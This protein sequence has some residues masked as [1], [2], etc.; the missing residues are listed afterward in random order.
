[1]M[2]WC[3]RKEHATVV[4]D[5]GS[6]SVGASLVVIDKK[7]A[8]RIVVS[9]RED[10]PFRKKLDHED[11]I[12]NT[13]KTIENVLSQVTRQASGELYPR[14]VHVFLASHLFLPSL[15]RLHI[16][17]DVPFYVTKNFVDELIKIDV[18]KYKTE[19]FEKSLEEKKNDNV[20]FESKIPR[21]CL[22]GY[23]TQNPYDK[24]A[25]DLDIT[26]YIGMA[27]RDF[28]SGISTVVGKFYAGIVP[29][30]HSF[31]FVGFNVVSDT[32]LHDNNFVFIDIG[33]ELTEVVVCR[34][35]SISGLFSF[36]VGKNSL[37]RA[38][39]ERFSVGKAQ[40]LSLVRMYT[41]KQANSASDQKILAAME[42]T[43]LKFTDNLKKALGVLSDKR[44][45]PQAFYLVADDDV[46]PVFVEYLKS[47]KFGEFLA[48][49]K[50]PF[51][52]VIPSKFMEKFC[53][54]QAGDVFMTIEAIF[55]DKLE[56][57]KSW[58]L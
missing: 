34:E 55:V 14:S 22:N 54:G 56:K 52:M 48:L 45:L 5:V 3:G 28:I 53:H 40:A 31:P 10:M 21:I 51:S 9:A 24:Y 4:V 57:I 7:D 38:I 46:S 26:A 50:E 13:F 32:L 1:M 17:K 16:Q 58:L 19:I 35:N 44:L 12:S 42:D 23:R 6:S 36:P 47:D 11:L 39:S 41:E 33:G 27:S 25:H 37:I 18:E 8:P 30:V 43:R 2:F 49:N 20:V 15:R 29:I